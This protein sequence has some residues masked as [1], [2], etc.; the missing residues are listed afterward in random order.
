MADS[1]LDQL[2]SD[3]LKIELLQA[4]A[5][6]NLD[7]IPDEFPDR[8]R[9]ALA[10]IR[11]VAGRSDIQTV[12]AFVY[13]EAPSSETKPHGFVRVAHMQDGHGS[14]DGCIVATN[15]DANNGMQRACTT[16][17]PAAMMEELE[18]LGLGDRC[19]VI[20]DP[21]QRVATIYPVGVANDDDH[22]RNVIAASKMDLEQ[23][24][25]CAPLDRTYNENLCNR[26]GRTIRMWSDGKLVSRAEDEIERHIK[27]QLS[28][29]FAGRQKQ[30][31]IL[32]QT[33]MTAGRADLIF[34][35]RVVA[36]GSRMVGVLE[37]KVL[38]G[39]AGE[40]KEATREGLS[41]G[42]FYRRDLELPFA[43]LAL[44]DVAEPPS[45]EVAALLNGQIAEHVAVVRVRRYPIYGSPKAWRDAGGLRAA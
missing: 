15:R 40:D 22:I 18:E 31:K 43:I 13:S 11:A 34:L 35:Q 42:Y 45:N 24:D 3:V 12:C 10:S 27:G 5:A 8:A 44:F 2:A 36:G 4:V 1:G 6:E 39:P 7:A 17:T 32:S 25:V 9:F 21:Q 33:N 38:R 29:F 37:L 30:I 20:W 14:L 23:D 28:M 41:Q 26:S 19:A 16:C